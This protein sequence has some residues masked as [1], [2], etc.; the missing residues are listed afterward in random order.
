M[1]SHTNGAATARAKGKH[2]VLITLEPRDYEELVR[3]AREQ[4]RSVSAQASYL[5]SQHLRRG[6]TPQDQT[7]HPYPLIK[8]ALD[9]Y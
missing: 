8:T 9:Q 5:L 2:P 3:Q 6:G 1:P 7:T 4:F